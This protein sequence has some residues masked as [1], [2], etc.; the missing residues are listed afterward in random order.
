MITL[1]RYTIFDKQCTVLGFINIFQFLT[2]FVIPVVSG[3]KSEV[4][5]RTNFCSISGVIATSEG[6]PCIEECLKDP[7]DMSTE[8]IIEV[9]RKLPESYV[10][11]M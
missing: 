6:I 11:V 9:L 8:S 10:R 1:S 7:N 5:V 4:R 3:D 2:L